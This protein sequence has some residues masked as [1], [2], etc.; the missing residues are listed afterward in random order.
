MHF[1]LD[2]NCSYSIFYWFE[3]YAWSGYCDIAHIGET[4]EQVILA[5]KICKNYVFSRSIKFGEV[6]RR[7]FQKGKRILDALLCKQDW[8]CLITKAAVRRGKRRF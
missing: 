6:Q 7:R 8:N 4:T 1:L 5:G 3:A 2:T